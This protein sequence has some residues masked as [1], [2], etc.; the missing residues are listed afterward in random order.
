VFFVFTH[1]SQQRLDQRPRAFHHTKKHL[2]LFFNTTPQAKQK[3][4]IEMQALAPSRVLGG[5]MARP[6]LRTTPAQRVPLRPMAALRS[7]DKKVRFWRN[8]DVLRLEL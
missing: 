6:A 4:V 7:S 8:S 2:P 1:T 3:Q 5:R